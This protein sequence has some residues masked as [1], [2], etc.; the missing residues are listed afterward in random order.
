M[1]KPD[2]ILLIA[3]AC[4]SGLFYEQAPGINFLIFNIVIIIL[5]IIGKKEILG[6]K[7]W[8]LAAVGAL[9][10]SL[11]IAWHGNWL[12]FIANVIS[13]SLLSLLA[14]NRKNSVGAA[15]ALSVLGIL[16]SWYHIFVGIFFPKNPKENRDPVLTSKSFWN[17]ILIYLIPVVVFLVFVALYRD[18][19]PVF[20]HLVS[21]IN[22]DFISIFW[23]LFTI[24]GW[25]LM[26]SYFKP[27]QLKEIIE[28]DINASGTI[29]PERIK[30][31]NWLNKLF[32]PDNENRSGIVLFG[33]LNALL[34]VVNV[35]DINFTLLGPVTGAQLP[36]GMSYSMIVHEGINSLI[37][38]IVL[39]VLLILYHFRGRLNFYESNK[40][41]KTLAYLWIAQN[42]FMVFSICV[43]NYMYISNYGLTPKRIGV[44]FYVGLCI[45]GLFYTL[46]KIMKRHTNWQLVRQVSWVF[47][48]ILV[49]S[50]IINWEAYI[51][52]YNYAWQQ[53]W[54]KKLD[55]HYLISL[56]ASSL[57]KLVDA[58]NKSIVND[59]IDTP[60]QQIDSKIFEFLDR[61]NNID[62]RS[63]NI[64][65]ESAFQ[66]INDL[67]K[68]KKLDTLYLSVN[69]IDYGRQ[70]EKMK[71][72]AP[73][74]I[75][76]LSFHD[77]F[78]YSFEIFG[79]LETLQE[80]DFNHSS[81]NSFSGIENL[82]NLQILKLDSLPS[83][84]VASLSQSALKKLIIKHPNPGLDM[85]SL[86]TILPHTEI[87]TNK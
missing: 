72:L 46:L 15:L 32:S 78:L 57:G 59:T 84:N 11:C 26:Y 52:D 1:K 82:K 40:T 86:R 24:L 68:S 4:Y 60:Y 8:R 53:R 77:S 75:K 54:N 64:D 49:L 3:V 30:P 31:N 22:L 28:Y 61:K 71:I 5:S 51:T 38:S 80:I 29:N 50:C 12:S 45:I 47:Y 37:W 44:Y 2:L 79:P 34:L 41:L 33:L 6:Y 9:L 14:L 73:L 35:I 63:W 74:K 19:N 27:W 56:N 10:S 81:V 13:L 23:V 43:R 7:T 87:I 42:I 20:D 48:G 69:E 21:L 62:W 25:L 17:R 65:D 66:S 55:S 39:A 70:V 36:K 18:S 16:T 85:K 67:S 83:T 76:K 58:R